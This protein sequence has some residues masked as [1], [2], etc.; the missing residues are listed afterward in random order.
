MNH[1]GHERIDLPQGEGTLILQQSMPGTVMMIYR[2]D[3]K[4]MLVIEQIS[5]E[6]EKG[7]P[8]I[9]R[10]KIKYKSFIAGKIADAFNTVYA[11][12]CHR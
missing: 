9:R 10:S 3:D 12:I 2:D 1:K 11:Y 4:K 7:K 6:W 5:I 8:E